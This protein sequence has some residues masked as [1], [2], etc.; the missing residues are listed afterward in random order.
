MEQRVSLKSLVE[1]LPSLAAPLDA[2]A[3]DPHLSTRVT[4]PPG[5]VWPDLQIDEQVSA[6]VVLISA[7]G[8]MGKSYTSRAMAHALS[9]PRLDLSGV[10]V[11]SNT[12]MGRLYR[13]L[14][15]VGAANYLMALAGGT[16]ALILDGLDE[17]Q[18]LAGREHFVAFLED[19]AEFSAS[20]PPRGQVIMLGRP[21]AMLLT[22]AALTEYGV[23]FMRARLA[24]LSRM[25]AASMIDMTLDAGGISGAEYSVH[26]THQVP[27]GQ[28]RDALFDDLSRALGNAKDLSTEAGWEEVDSFLGYPPVLLA[29][30]TRL[31]VDN[32][33]DELNKFQSAT[34]PNRRVER[35]DLLK[36][37]IEHILDRESEKVRG[38]ICSALALDSDSAVAKVLYTRSE[39]MIRVMTT[40]AELPANSIL[41]PAALP[42]DQRAIYDE[43][44]TIFV[45]DHPLLVDNK[46]ANIV[47]ADYVRAYLNASTD[48]GLHGLSRAELLSKCQA[49]GPFFVHFMASLTSEIEG[50]SKLE[51]EDLADELI[52]SFVAGCAEDEYHLSFYTHNEMGA[53]LSLMSGP[54]Y[55][56]EPTTSIAFAITNPSGV[57]ELSTPILQTLIVSEH[58]VLFNAVHDEIDVG[59]NVTVVAGTMELGGK[60]LFVSS[61]RSD[62]ESTGIHLFIGEEVLHDPALKITASPE[63][64]TITGA[65]SGHQWRPYAQEM[66]VNVADSGRL[67][68]L[69]VSV[70]RILTSF[71]GGATD[72]GLHAEMLENLV[73]GRSASAQVALEGLLEIGV[74]AKKGMLYVLVANNIRPFGLSYA[75]LRS[76]EFA[77]KLQPLMNELRGLPSVERF[78]SQSSA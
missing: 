76:S 47:F 8:A 78:L 52:S 5:Y 75:D 37:T 46:L 36:E 39:Q 34:R 40:V 42:M 69:L 18:L 58:A 48:D 60:R 67:Y 2:R 51:S 22:E 25:Q 16:A 38:R 35:G 33:L 20:A 31:K 6:P 63:E 24:P 44:V 49:A 13:T 71:R 3:A 50:E 54:A 19:I 73:V 59:P 62:V 4:L 61:K 10:R 43:Q 68:Q 7:P 64:L 15:S 23:S 11:G 45:H 70:R 77:T 56:P 32:P 72:P 28:L 74:V 30:A 53:F 1:S 41:S 27:F 66:D 55:S 29:L 21:D 17:A 14:G 12:L 26:R 9:A 57:L 65:R